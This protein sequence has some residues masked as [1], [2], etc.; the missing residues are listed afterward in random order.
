MRPPVDGHV[1]L[2]QRCSHIWHG[3]VKQK[4]TKQKKRKRDQNN[5]IAGSFLA[6]QSDSSGSEPADEGDAAEAHP[7]EE[8]GAGRPH[9]EV[10]QENSQLREQGAVWKQVV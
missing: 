6:A 8:D 5:G 4:K 7:P 9:D 1:C 3:A 2:H 10:L